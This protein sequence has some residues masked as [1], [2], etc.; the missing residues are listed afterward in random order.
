MASM[1]KPRDGIPATPEHMKKAEGYESDE[2]ADLTSLNSTY[3]PRY[4]S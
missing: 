4:A 3:F 2:P 1:G